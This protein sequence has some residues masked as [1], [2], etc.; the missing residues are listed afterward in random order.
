LKDCFKLIVGDDNSKYLCG[1]EA[2][3]HLNNLSDYVK[4]LKH[5]NTVLFFE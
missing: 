2:F 3:E 1:K 5:E 4:E